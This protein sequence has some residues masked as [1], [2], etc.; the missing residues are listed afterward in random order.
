[1]SCRSH[2]TSCGGMP[3]D[4]MSKNIGSAIPMFNVQCS[5]FM[6]RIPC[7]MFHVPCSMFNVPS[8]NVS[9]FQCFNVSM[10]QCFNVSMFQ[11]FNV[12]M[13]QCF[14]VSMF[15]CSMFHV[16]SSK[17]NVQCSMFMSCDLIS[18]HMT[19]S[20]PFNVMSCHHCKPRR[21]VSRH[22]MSC[23]QVQRF[24]SYLASNSATQSLGVSRLAM[25]RR[26]TM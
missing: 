24:K 13:F 18:C 10:F 7:S 20:F 23:T 25:P 5:M 21:V 2:V 17:F 3:C 26:S 6:F 1:M 19:S 22:A 15:Q 14:N 16:Q 11:C 12:S 8:F 4:V 9:M